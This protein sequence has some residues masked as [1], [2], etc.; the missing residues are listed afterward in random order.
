MDLLALK[1]LHLRFGFENLIVESRSEQLI[2]I[3]KYHKPAK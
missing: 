3:F 1:D 2:T